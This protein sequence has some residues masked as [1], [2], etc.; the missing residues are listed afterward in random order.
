MVSTQEIFIDVKPV[1]A[2]GLKTF[3]IIQNLNDGMVS[4]V[5][6]VRS[7]GMESVFYEL[8]KLT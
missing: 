7:A 4:L 3:L 2:H 5:P 8:N 6:N 1:N